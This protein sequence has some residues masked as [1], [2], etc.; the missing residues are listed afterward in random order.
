MTS[1]QFEFLKLLIQL[2]GALTIAWLAVRWALSRYKSEKK[3]ERQLAAYAD[4]V[5]SISQMKRLV[6]QWHDEAISDFLWSDETKEERKRLYRDSRRRLEEAL[7][8][9][10]L[11]L[12]RETTELLERL[13]LDIDTDT[14]QSM[15]EQ[16]DNE[17]G[18]L[19]EALKKLTAQG[20]VAIGS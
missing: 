9:A 17:W 11:L 1:I 3:W 7:A 15:A 16:L 5:A 10:L 14:A 20:R 19:D 2:T 4:A 12:P 6:G 8:S 18:F 13:M